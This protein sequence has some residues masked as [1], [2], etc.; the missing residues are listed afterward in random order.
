M[1]VQLEQKGLLTYFLSFRLANLARHTDEYF[2]ALFCPILHKRTQT[3]QLLSDSF[4]E[5]G[6]CD[7]YKNSIYSGLVVSI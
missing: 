2:L 1:C 6:T 3:G 7:S 4:D 5:E